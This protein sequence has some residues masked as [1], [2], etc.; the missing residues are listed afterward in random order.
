MTDPVDA[1]PGSTSGPGSED[2]PSRAVNDSI[3]IRELPAGAMITLRDGATAAVV[4]NPQDGGWLFVK[5]IT[6]AGDPDRVG[7]EEMVFCTDVVG[8]R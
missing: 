1:A 5:I 6:C 2:N 3:L 7:T 4:A 8:A